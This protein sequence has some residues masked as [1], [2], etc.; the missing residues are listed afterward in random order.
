MILAVLN[1]KIVKSTA[2]LRNQL[3]LLGSFIFFYVLGMIASF[4]TVV[5][6]FSHALRILWERIGPSLCQPHHPSSSATA[7]LWC[8]LRVRYRVLYQWFVCLSKLLEAGVFEGLPCGH[9][10]IWVIHQEL[11]DYILNVWLHM[12]YQLCYTS[13]LLLWKVELHMRGM[14]LIKTK[15]IRVVRDN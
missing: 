2:V 3:T 6:E 10:V 4:A 11:Y 15:W 5:R 12:G 7:H 9:A 14:P 1:F 13:A 8:S